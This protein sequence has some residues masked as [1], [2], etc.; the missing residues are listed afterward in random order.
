M[1]QEGRGGNGGNS[2]IWRI[3]GAALSVAALVCMA[4][5][6][7]DK[8][9]KD[10]AE[11]AYRQLAEQT[12]SVPAVPT[13]APAETS[14]PVSIPETPEPTQEPKDPL[15]ELGVPIPDKTVDFE[16]LQR[17]T[18]KDIY[19]WIYLPDSAIDYPVLQHPD[20]NAYYLDY[21]LDGSKGYPGCI[22]SENYNKK[23]FTDPVTVLY[24][25]NMRNSTMFG[26]LHK[27]SDEAWFA[28]HPYV[29]IY[30]QE[31]LLVYKVFAAHEHTDEHLLYAYDYEKEDVFKAFI[32]KVMKSRGT[33]N[34]VVDD[35]VEIGADSRILT[36]STCIRY[37]PEYRFLV[38][39]VLLNGE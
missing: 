1:E 7:A 12:E 31:K 30:T 9:R 17:D 2:R 13:E 24:G 11:D 16:A 32:D 27:F 39:G 10:A 18:N 4:A 15:E 23:D 14:V 33:D 26:G 20:D 29:Y 28:E 25:H 3:A 22:Y 38:H 5:V 21:N 8:S 6:W 19:A 35:T 37:R 36:L 34:A